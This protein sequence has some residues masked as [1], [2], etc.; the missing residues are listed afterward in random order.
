MAVDLRDKVSFTFADSEEAPRSTNGTTRV[1]ELPTGD[2]TL[3]SRAPTFAGAEFPHPLS[4]VISAAAATV[5]MIAAR[6]PLTS[7]RVGVGLNDLTS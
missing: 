7:L 6:K 2:T 4:E 3:H 1:D 5:G